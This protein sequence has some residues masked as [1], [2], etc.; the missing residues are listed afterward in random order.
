M[1]KRGV[2]IP[3]VDSLED[4]VVLSHVGSQLLSSATAE[5]RKLHTSINNKSVAADFHKLNRGLKST[6]HNVQHTVD[7]QVTSVVHHVQTQKTTNNF[8]DSLKKMF[9]FK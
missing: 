6:F 3:R 4:R 5:F 1:R 9:G 2:T 7:H 8:W